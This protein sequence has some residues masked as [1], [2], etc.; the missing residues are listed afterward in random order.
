MSSRKKFTVYSQ[1]NMNGIDGS[2]V[3]NQSMCLALAAIEDTEVTLLLTAGVENDRLL[4]PLLDHPAIQ[5]LDP[6]DEGLIDE[7]KQLNADVAA[8]V[9]ASLMSPHERHAVVVR[10]TAVALRFAFRPELAGRLWLY[11]TDFPQHVLDLDATWKG[12]MAQVAEAAQVVLCQTEEIRTFLESNF[13]G[14]AGKCWRLTP[15]VPAE[16]ERVAL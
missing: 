2:S 5:V 14:F 16:V 12:D 13:A 9:I 10:G 3:W 15:S 6:V 4:A 1:A 8:G 7:R 11:L